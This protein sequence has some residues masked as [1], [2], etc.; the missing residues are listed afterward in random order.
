MRFAPA[1]LLTAVIVLAAPFMGVLRDVLFDRFQNTAVRSLGLALLA[2]AAAVFLFAILR[3]R[4]NRLPRYGGLAAAATLL[5]LQ[6]KMSSGATG[7]A[8]Q[9]SV[10]EKIHIVEY[11]LLVY[12][13]YRAIKPAA[14]LRL[15]ILP[16]LG[17]ILAGV[18]DEGMQLLVE[19][20]LGEIRDVWLNVYAGFCGLVFSF[21]L[22]P[23]SRF[24]WRLSRRG[25]EVV[26]RAAATTVLALGLF[27]AAAHLGYEHFDPSIGRFRSWHTLEELDRAAVDRAAKWQADPPTELSPWRREDPYLTEAG[28][29]A[30]HRNER[31]RAGDLYLAAQAN[32]ILET[33]YAPFLD[34]KSFR[35]SGIHRYPPDVRSDLEARAP[36]RNPEKYSSPVLV[37]RIVLWPSK[38]LFFALLIPVVLLLAGLPNILR[39]VQR[40]ARG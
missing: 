25:T 1:V 35:G 12:L 7:F 18:L 13:L 36:Q 8:A 33:Y 37:H 32:R 15:L 2:L 3:I 17:V 28:W 21:A 9:V 10:A 14:D 5:W 39:W 40:K 11:G 20:R 30:N 4:Q 34:L 22:D 24:D 27:F 19:T 6:L 23:P 26:S 29:H 38:R 31:Y 16:L